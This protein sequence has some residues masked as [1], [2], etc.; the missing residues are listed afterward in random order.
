MNFL[1][2][3]PIGKLPV[4]HQI[5]LLVLAYLASVAYYYYQWLTTGLLPLPG[6][7]WVTIFA[8]LYEEVLFRG[9][10]FGGLLAFY[11]KRTAIVLSSFLFGI[12]HLKNFSA[13]TPD[14]M[15]YQVLYAGLIIGPFLAWLTLKTK[16]IWMGV[17]VHTANNIL[18]SPLSWWVAGL[19]GVEAL[20]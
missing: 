10:I 18:L 1:P 14:A 6:N 4:T 17:L 5:V 12:W 9:L 13:Y 16:S 8:P 19:F 15:L 2:L 11:S 3:R 20:F 7:H